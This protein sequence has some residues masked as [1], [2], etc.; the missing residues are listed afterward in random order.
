MHP[1]IRIICF[2]ILSAF[3]VF[4]GLYELALGLLIVLGVVIVR[5]FQS[6]ELSLRIIRRM[7]WFFLSILIVYL[8]FTPG[9]PFMGIDVTGM[10][11]EEGLKTG[12]LRVL[13][14][15]LI[16][17]AVNYF[18]TTIARIKLVEAIIWLL[19]PMRWAGIDNRTIALRIAMVLEFLPRVQQMVLDVKQ[20]YLHTPSESN[21]GKLETRKRKLKEKLSVAGLLVEQLFVR[22]VDEAVRTPH[23][24]INLAQASHPPLIQWIFP[25]LLSAL[26]V[27]VKL[28]QVG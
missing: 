12:A 25:V 28:L 11:T 20:D 6:V 13:S 15:A 16:I 24:T 10:P 3:V 18:V 4:G 22:V 27:W 7:K 26:F 23:E 17:F 9:S 19:Y 2:L 21:D 5:R 8:W 1:V 14:L